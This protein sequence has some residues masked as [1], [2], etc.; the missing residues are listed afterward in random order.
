MIAEIV[1]VRRIEAEGPESGADRTCDPSGIRAFGVDFAPFRMILRGVVVD[2]G[3]QVDRHIDI[4]LL[5]RIHLRAEKIE[6]QIRVH[7]PDA[8]RMV[9][10]AVV[11]ER[12]TGDGIN[13]RRLETL[14]PLLL[15]EPF[16]DSGNIGRC[17]KIQMDLSETQLIHGCHPYSTSD[18]WK[19]RR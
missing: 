19:I 10:H 2:A 14:L 8:G 7:H 16:S 9:A 15:V 12:K 18:V 3:R 11:A 4:D 13:M 6:F 1:E 5:A 17:V